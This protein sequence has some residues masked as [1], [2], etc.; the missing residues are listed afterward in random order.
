MLMTRQ[1]CSASR[2]QAS[3]RWSTMAVYDANTRLESQ[4][5]RMNYQTFSTGLS[6]G[7]LAGSGTM[8]MLGGTVSRSEM[9]HPA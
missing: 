6:S 9:C 7:H 5:A 1:G 2:F 3:Q 8:V 4:L